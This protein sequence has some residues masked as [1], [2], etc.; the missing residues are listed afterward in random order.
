MPARSAVGP[1]PTRRRPRSRHPTASRSPDRLN[2]KLVMPVCPGT[3]SVTRTP[4]PAGPTSRTSD[5]P[6]ATA[7]RIVPARSKA[8]PARPRPPAVRPAAAP[9]PTSPP[10]RSGTRRRPTLPATGRG[11]D[12]RPPL[13]GTSSAVNC[14]TTVPAD[15]V[16]NH[17]PVRAPARPRPSSPATPRP[18]GLT[19][20]WTRRRKSPGSSHVRPGPGRGP[21]SARCRRDGHPLAVGRHAQTE[22][23]IVGDGPPVPLGQ[24][25]V[26]SG[27]RGRRHTPAGPVVSTSDSGQPADP[28]APVGSGLL[29]PDRLAAGPGVVTPPLAG[30]P[31]PRTGR[32]GPS[33]GRGTSLSPA[34]VTRPTG[35]QTGPRD[36]L[37]QSELGAP[38]EGDQVGPGGQPGDP[39]ERARQAEG[40]AVGGRV[41]HPERPGLAPDQQP[42]RGEQGRAGP[43]CRC[44]AVAVKLRALSGSRTEMTGPTTASRSPV[45]SHTIPWA[46]A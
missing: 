6:Q 36:T 43:G 13:A 31:G 4:S 19:T 46:S 39:A 44:R 32:P 12:R 18:S 34:W 25:A 20:A 17:R 26:R 5:P 42:V 37:P 23:R 9:A 35:R 29:Q 30:C 24:P 40:D 7:G 1:G 28:V 22:R 14:L 38:A 3:V 8:I 15:G 11:A 33:P 16:P 2:P 27:T 41:P 21:A 10:P 45:R